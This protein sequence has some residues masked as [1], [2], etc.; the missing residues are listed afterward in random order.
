MRW[1]LSR[2]RG[3]RARTDAPAAHTLGFRWA[4]LVAVIVAAISVTA[5]CAGSA[6]AHAVLVRSL[7]EQNARLK[8]APNRVDLFF[9]EPLNR[10]FSTIRVADGAGHQHDRGNV[11]FTADPTEMAID[12]S[13]LDPG[14]YTVV[15]SNV[16]AADGHRWDGTFPFIVLNP[17]GSVPAGAIPA[18]AEGGAS[19][20]AQPFDVALRWLLLLGL[21]GATGAFAFTA[22]V[23]Y[24]SSR[25]LPAAARSAVRTW[26]L[27]LTGTFAAAAALVVLI[28]NAATLL[29]SAA[30][31]GSIGAIPDL[32][33]GS[34]GANWVGRELLALLV[35][36]IA[37]ALGRGA[38]RPDGLVAKGLLAAGALSG[39]GGLLTLALTSHAA[40]GAGS[41][42]AV[43]AEFVHLSAVAVWLGC[44]AVLPA[45]LR[46]PVLEGA[47]RRRLQAAA[48][49][50]FTTLALGAV[51]LAIVSGAFSALIEFPSLAALKDTAYGRALIV[52][53]L[54]LLPLFSLGLVNVT[55][56]ARRFAR[57]ASAD[58]GR[59]SGQLRRLVRSAVA[60][61]VVAGAVIAAAATM[62]FFAPARDTVPSTPGPTPAETAFAQ[63]L[64]VS[65]LTVSLSV[66]PNQPGD[67]SYRV[68]LAGSDIDRVQRVRLRFA[69]HGARSGQADVIAQPVDGSPGIFT[70]QAANLG[71]AGRWRITVNVR[72]AGHDDIDAGFTDDVASLEPSRSATAFPAHGISEAQTWAALALA[73]LLLALIMERDHILARVGARARLAT[74]VAAATAAA[75]ALIAVGTVALLTAAGS[76]AGSK[77]VGESTPVQAV[78]SQGMT[79]WPVPTPDAGLMVPAVGPDGRIWISEMTSNKLAVL[80]PATNTY[81]EY[82]PSLPTA[83][84]MGIVVDRSG[85][86]WLA[87]GAT[88]SIGRF[89]PRS[90]DYRVFATPTINSSPSGI[91]LDKQGR[92]WF[93]ELGRQR[94]GVFDP[95]SATFQEYPL[96]NA[97][98]TPYWLDVGPD[99][100][101]WFTDLSV[102]EVG[103]LT[104]GSGHID[105]FPVPGAQGTTGIDVAPDGTVWFGVHGRPNA[106]GHLDPASGQISTV[107][108]PSGDIY[109]ISVDRGGAVWAA[110]VRDSVYAFDPGTQA[111]RAYPTGKG[112][113]WVAS[114]ADGSVWVAVGDPTTNALTRILAPAA[115]RLPGHQAEII[116]RNR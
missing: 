89:D 39:L 90:G 88:G 32:L 100:R 16:S 49:G 5:S 55:R 24:P 83:G 23:L 79:S 91:A 75:M 67:D 80:D 106:L 54:L 36:A 30:Q 37:L 20:G 82:R 15:W 111:F 61:T 1:C 33:T 109:G 62:V 29:R 25:A 59:T 14:I 77:R 17:D 86:V 105:L 87:Q 92:I 2:D 7:P 19:G 116:V 70:A 40:A 66:A 57:F 71:A 69:G 108:V 96:P 11:T 72:R 74:V 41:A 98:S 44:L 9:S 18:S 95:A 51:L 99:G 35:A 4:A 28:V 46:L 13:P 104:P 81:T 78:Q 68:Q 8:T 65:D 31:I 85:L 6:Q 101:V 53:G 103:V 26:S 114:A 10:S 64:T 42:W 94:I 73:V 43:P 34:V 27:Q 48:L 60:E 58:D 107:P 63:R 22:F 38:V 112:S 45:L 113:W 21:F 50:R 115:L 56:I 97:H 110:S 102:A 52:K 84:T 3:A 76:G 93:T 12:L 47:E